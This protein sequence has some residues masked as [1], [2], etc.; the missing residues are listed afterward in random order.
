MRWYVRK[1]F[2]SGI[3]N[4]KCNNLLFS[5]YFIFSW[6]SFLLFIIAAHRD[7]EGTWFVESAISTDKFSEMITVT[8]NRRT[9]SITHNLCLSSASETVTEE[10]P[11]DFN[12]Q[13]YL[14]LEV[15]HGEIN[16]IQKYR[17]R[18]AP[19]PACKYC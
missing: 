1:L 19:R 5:I 4:L 6:C 3:P 14:A 8:I 11:L 7:R 17:P 13:L 10:I 9:Q 12:E 16:G 2:L 15:F 18:H